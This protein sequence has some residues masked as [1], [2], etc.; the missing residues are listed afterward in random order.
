MGDNFRVSAPD[1]LG[2]CVI[3]VPLQDLDVALH[4]TNRIDAPIEL[5]YNASRD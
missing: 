5:C 3:S 4:L 1:L 2:I